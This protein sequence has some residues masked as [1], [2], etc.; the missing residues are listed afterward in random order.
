MI[1]LRYRVPEATVR[2]DAVPCHVLGRSADLDMIFR[3][4]LDNAVKYAGATPQ[5]VV[6]VRL[7]RNGVVVQIADNGRGIPA[8]LRRK[9]FERFVRLGSELEREK[10]GTGL[11]LYIVRTLV[12]RLGGTIRVSDREGACGAVFELHLPGSACASDGVVFQPDTSPTLRGVD[13]TD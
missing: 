11:G 3:N 10:P 1:C 7:E 8:P 6:S 13:E 4:L 12:R 9:I 5:V 2:L